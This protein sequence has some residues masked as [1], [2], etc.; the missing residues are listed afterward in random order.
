MLFLSIISSVA[1][2][3]LN[4]I[5]NPRMQ[6]SYSLL[7]D[8]LIKNHSGLF[9]CR[10]RT[11]DSQIVTE[12]FERPLRRYFDA[13]KAGTFVDVGAHVGKYTV[14]IS[15]QVQNRGRVIAVEADIQNFEAL[16]YNIK[17]NRLGNVTALNVACWDEN[18]R[19]RLYRDST[20]FGTGGYSAIERYQGDYLY[21]NAKKLDDILSEL[22]V[23]VVDFMKVDI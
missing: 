11:S 18:S 10:A 13:F 8:C 4:N 23:D 14:Q 20:C 12:V 6:L 9:H 17:L 7:R 15:R 1:Y 3:F 5:R 2:Y 19:I 22:K 21:T 16:V